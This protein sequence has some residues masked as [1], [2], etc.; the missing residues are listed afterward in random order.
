MI[1]GDWMDDEPDEWDEDLQDPY[2]DCPKCGRSIYD[3]AEQCP[4]CFAYLTASD[5][6]RPQSL[7]VIGI[8]VLLV[9]LLILGAISI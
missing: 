9:I 4:Y 5:F 3:D 8:V 1:D 7:W 2:V 6:K